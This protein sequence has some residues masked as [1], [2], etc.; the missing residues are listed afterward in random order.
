MIHH[1]KRDAVIRDWKQG[2]RVDGIARARELS[3]TDIIALLLIE[4]V[5]YW[6]ITCR[7]GKRRNQYPDIRRQRVATL[8]TA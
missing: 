6:R 2:F 4:G 1:L 3:E 8:L 7:E 5:P